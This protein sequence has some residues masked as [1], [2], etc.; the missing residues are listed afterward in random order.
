MVSYIIKRLLHMIPVTLILSFICFLVID[1]APGDFVSIYQTR[2]MSMSS[3]MTQEAIQ[4]Q[5]EFLDE[6]RVLYGLD[7][8]ILQRYFTWLFGI[9]TRG[10]FGYAYMV[11]RPVSTIIWE[12]LGWTLVLTSCSM[13][14]ALLIGFVVGVYAATHQ[15]GV[16]DYIAT[17]TSYVGLAVPSFFLA[18]LLMTMVVFVFQGQVGGLFSAQYVAAPWSWNKLLDLLS[19]L[20]IPVLIVGTAGAASNIR[21]VR[22]NLL[23]V[24]GQPY[25]Q[26][27]RAK[28]QAERF[29]I[30]RHALRNSLHPLIMRIGSSLP[31]LIAGEIIVSIVLGLPTAGKTFYDALMYQDTYLAGS[32]LVMLAVLLQI[33]NLLADI[34]LIRIDPTI[35]Y[36]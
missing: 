22:G 24:L 34:A 16:V 33:G 9:V 10:D 1:I 18:L 15:Y 13:I 27:A 2:I 17:F 28:G 21:I 30:Y 5:L 23:D 6:M 26:T 31:S 3:Q 11:M 12:K 8:P 36:D 35:S 7:K 14:F 29:V 19:H 25:V 20:W 32:F 4:A